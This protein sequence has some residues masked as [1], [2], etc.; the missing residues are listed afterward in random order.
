MP[1]LGFSNAPDGNGRNE[2]SPAAYDKS[3]QTATLWRNLSI[4][5]GFASP[6]PEHARWRRRG[7]DFLIE[8]AP[9][10]AIDVGG[11]DPPFV[12]PEENVPGSRISDA[13]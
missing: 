13:R 3:G 6:A 4:R 5:P 9:Y 12:T 11:V 8:D 2:A 1:G 7:W 10:A